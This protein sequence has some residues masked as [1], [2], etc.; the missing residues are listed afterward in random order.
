MR[1]KAER[2]SIM[3]RIGLLTSTA[4]TAVALLLSNTAT[5]AY[6]QT[7]MHVADRDPNTRFLCTYGQ[8]LVSAFSY[9]GGSSH[10]SGWQ[11]VAVPITGHG[12][13]VS[14]IEVVEAQS[15]QTYHSGF[16]VGIYSNTARGFPGKLVAGGRGKIGRT[17]G[18]VNVSIP[19][20]TLNSR[21]TYWVEE[22]A[23]GGH[24]GPTTLYW[25]ANPDTK[26]KAYVRY[27]RYRFVS[28]SSS[29]YTSPWREQSTGPDV[30]LK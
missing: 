14:R 19:P 29:D 18:P 23:A 5:R 25:E 8:F 7:N 12:Q 24:S 22:R 1:Q 9:G 6:A 13:T 30:R 27:H 3:L 26:R 17:C 21:T 4:M 15:A 20:T 16:K 10:F 28:G 2:G 11:Y